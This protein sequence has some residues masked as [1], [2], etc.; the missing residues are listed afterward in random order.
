VFIRP[1]S[2]KFNAIQIGELIAGALAGSWRKDPPTT[3]LSQSEL[4]IIAP[5]LNE[6]GGTGLLWWRIRNTPVAA[7]EIGRSIE[8]GYKLLRLAELN[9]ELEIANVFSILRA[10]GIEAVLVKGWA[11]ARRY[12]SAGLRPYGDIDLCLRPEQLRRATSALKCLEKLE[13]HYVDL[14]SGFE[15][16]GM[17]PRVTLSRGQRSAFIKERAGWPDIEQTE[18][19]FAR[20]Q[21]VPLGKQHVRILRKEDHLRV[22]C[23]HLLRSGAWRPLWLCDV[24]LMLET[25][26][27][28]FD[29]DRC[30]GG[31]RLQANW[32]KCTIAL[33]THLLRVRVDFP[34]AESARHLPR[35]LVPAVLRQWGRG[36]DPDTAGASL[37]SLYANWTHPAKA[38]REMAARWDRPVRATVAIRGGFNNWPRFPY[39]LGELLSRLPEL[40]LAK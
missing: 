22:L 34:F 27:G 23:L 9:H 19:L 35:W 39:Q 32:I 6:T 4:I 28:E 16:I 1:T 18:E 7:T 25:L 13:G 21:V 37:P 31:D 26:D 30:L 5:K 2:A 33:A 12:P 40:V 29:W 38:W 8:A 15:R 20:A 11:I 36:R 3:D 17:K 14:H 24:A 10:E